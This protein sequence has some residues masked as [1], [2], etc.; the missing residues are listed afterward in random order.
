MFCV[1]S[2]KG[3]CNIKRKY[4]DDIGVTYRPDTWNEDDQRQSRWAQE[5]ETYGFDERETWSLNYS[6]RLWLYERL[7]R[8][9]DVCCFNLEYHKFEYQ[10]KEYSQRQM[11][12]MML[13]RLEFSFKPEHNDLDDEQFR[14]VNEIGKI[15][16]TVLP[17]MWW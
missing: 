1:S 6:F 12:D 17:A 15:W 8:F 11:I 10:G 3:R 2:Q 13:E 9:V 14:Y 16:A 4:L 5:R 7:K